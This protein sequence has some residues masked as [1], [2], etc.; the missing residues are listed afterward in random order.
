VSPLG[1][2]AVVYMGTGYLLAWRLVFQQFYSGFAPLHLVN[3]VLGILVTTWFAAIV[4]VLAWPYLMFRL[5]D[6]RS[7]DTADRIGRVLAGESREDKLERRERE[8]L[9]REER[10]AELE[11]ELQVAA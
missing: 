2:I 5:V 4:W 11:R 8:V 10:I 7:G 1:W 9:E 3:L 6:A